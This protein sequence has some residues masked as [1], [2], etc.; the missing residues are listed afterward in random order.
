M[1][2]KQKSERKALEQ[3]AYRL[4]ISQTAIPD[5]VSDITGAPW[6]IHALLRIAF[7]EGYRNGASMYEVEE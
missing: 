6:S 5:R 2:S 1:Q 4:S 7:E 3:V